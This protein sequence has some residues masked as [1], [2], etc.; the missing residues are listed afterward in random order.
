MAAKTTSGSGFDPK[1]RL[2]A[3]SFL[4]KSGFL[5]VYRQVLSDFTLTHARCRQYHCTSCDIGAFISPKLKEAEKRNF[6]HS[7]TVLRSL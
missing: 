4:L 6:P 1:F 2:L 5:A 7:H 3:H